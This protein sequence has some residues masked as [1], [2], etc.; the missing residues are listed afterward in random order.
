MQNLKEYAE[1]LDSLYDG[2]YCVDR[3]FRIIFWNRGAERLT[4][5]S[6]EEVIGSRCSDNLLR[7]V[8]QQGHELCVLG[9]PL[10]AT[11]Q[12]GQAREAEVYL[13][14]REGHRVPVSVRCTPIRDVSGEVFAALEIFSDAS[15]LENLR[16][17]L[18]ELEHMAFVDPLTQIA[19]RRFLDLTIDRRLQEMRRFS[20]PFGVILA[21]VDHFKRFND[22]WGHETGDK[23]LRMVAQTLAVNLRPFDVAGRWGGEEF[24]AVVANV[25]KDLLGTIAERSRILVKASFLPGPEGPL[26]VTVSLGATC[27]REEDTPETLF[28]RVDDLLYR[29]KQ[30]GRDRVTLEA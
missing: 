11:L 17:R 20:W 21:D 14:H 7:H 19:N 13:H 5:Y 22:T 16:Q 9:C 10:H 26:A 3:D 29:S 18:E 30:N 2:V 24:L 27:A 25:D 23:V 28:R 4:G 8:D 12:D 15:T 6:R 1:L